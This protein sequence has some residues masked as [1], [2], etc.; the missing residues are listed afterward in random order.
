MNR[1]SVLNRTPGGKE[2]TLHSFKSSKVAIWLESTESQTGQNSK[3][4]QKTNC[5]VNDHLGSHI[6]SPQCRGK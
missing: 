5:P 6:Y 4:N 2:T 3:R 1:F